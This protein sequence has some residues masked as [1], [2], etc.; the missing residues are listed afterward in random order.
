M[1]GGQK[2]TTA[3]FI[4]FVMLLVSSYKLSAQSSNPIQ[5]RPVVQTLVDSLALTKEVADWNPYGRLLVK[6]N[7]TA[8]PNELNALTNHNNPIIR[9][10]AFKV[11]AQKHDPQIFPILLNHLNDTARIQ[12]LIVD[13][14]GPE[15]VADYF[16]NIVT[17]GVIDTGL[18][19]LTAIQKLKVDSILL[20][21]KTIRLT[22]KNKLLYDLKPQ[23]KHYNRVRQIAIEEKNPVAGYTLA[24]YKKK[25]DIPI[26]S[27]FLNDKETDYYAMYAARDFPNPTYYPQ[28]VKIFEREWEKKL[29]SFGEW[30]ILYEALAKYPNKQTLKLFER[31]VQT[32]DSYRNQTLGVDLMVALLKYPN[33]IF[34]SVKKRIKLDSTSKYFVKQ[35][36]DT[37][38]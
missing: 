16:L 17:P 32:K 35:R 1:V 30:E 8:F 27:E 34:N 4:C 12:V 26:I 24:R 29:Y 37:E 5:I 18:Y 7:K 10:Y 36:I 14:S 15:V 13:V 22:N 33:P 21:D 28:L 38:K 20:Y 2:I 23:S 19:E 6:L 3:L 11:L 31:T 9:C 25:Q